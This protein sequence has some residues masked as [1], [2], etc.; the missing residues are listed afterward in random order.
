MY[1][2]IYLYI[3]I[4]TYMYIFTYMYVYV[5]IHIYIYIYIYIYTYIDVY[6]IL[7]LW[8]FSHNIQII[9]RTLDENSLLL[10]ALTILRNLSFEASN[11]TLIG[12]STCLLRHFVSLI[13]ASYGVN[14]GL[15]SGMYVYIYFEYICIYTLCIYMYIYTYTYIYIYICMHIYIY[16]YI[17]ML[18]RHF[19][20]LMVA[21]YG[22]N[23]D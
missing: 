1:D 16:I 19:V 17:H 12:S 5:H 6:I 20:P 22:V 7:T 14:T 23:T 11:E 10:T 18:I 21:T 15:N 13:V 2:F 3:Y 4:P 9:A 8:L